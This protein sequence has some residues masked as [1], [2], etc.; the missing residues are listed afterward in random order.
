[1]KRPFLWAFIACG[2]RTSLGHGH[3]DAA[4]DDASSV[5][6]ICLQGTVGDG[7]T[8]VDTSALDAFTKKACAPVNSN[9]QGAYDHG[10]CGTQVVAFH[11]LCCPSSCRESI[12]IINRPDKTCE[13]ISVVEARAPMFCATFGLSADSVMSYATSPCDAGTTNT[14]GVSCCP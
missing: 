12:G 11:Y 2:A 3:R 10:Q 1:M 6:H 7:V 5:H 14:T 8:C 13:P 9:W 4:L